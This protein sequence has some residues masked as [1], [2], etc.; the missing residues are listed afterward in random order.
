MYSMTLL[1]NNVM[2]LRETLIQILFVAYNLDQN[3]VNKMRKLV[4]KIGLYSEFFA[5]GF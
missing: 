5:A 3:I 4:S 1:T 2:P